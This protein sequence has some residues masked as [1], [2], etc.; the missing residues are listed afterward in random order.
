F[1]R[2]EWARYHR[3]RDVGRGDDENV[4]GKAEYE[5]ERE[6][7]DVDECERECRIP[8]PRK[9]NAREEAAERAHHD[10]AQSEVSGD[11]LPQVR[12]GHVLKETGESL[13]DLGRGEEPG[14]QPS[15]PYDLKHETDPREPRDARHCE[16]DPDVERDQAE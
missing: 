15:H 10:R 2:V 14:R 1:D 5:D 16:I 4:V 13:R 9:E 6:A 8:P 7:H 11:E 3:V 12:R